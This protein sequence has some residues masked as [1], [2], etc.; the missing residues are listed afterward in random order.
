MYNKVFYG[1]YDATLPERLWTSASSCAKRPASDDTSPDTLAGLKQLAQVTEH[2]W[3]VFTPLDTVATD[4]VR[5]EVERFVVVSKL[6]VIPEATILPEV[7]SKEMVVAVF[8]VPL[9][10]KNIFCK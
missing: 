10:V 5:T 1:W 4:E 2:I 7:P 8:E 6:V 9:G 3:E